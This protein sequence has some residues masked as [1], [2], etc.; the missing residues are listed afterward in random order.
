MSDLTKLTLSINRGTAAAGKQ[1]AERAGRSLS[2]IV[3]DYLDA[4]TAA[5]NPAPLSG[6]VASL[7]GIGS[8][9]VDER[10]WKAYREARQ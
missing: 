5:T 10:D 8:G 7:M 9:P 1:Y 2:S 3:G 4:L 6:D